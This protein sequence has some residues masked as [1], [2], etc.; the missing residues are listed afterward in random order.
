MKMNNKTNEY[1]HGKRHYQDIVSI[2]DRYKVLGYFKDRKI[3]DIGSSF[4]FF[5]RQ[6]NTFYREKKI[7]FSSSLQNYI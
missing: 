2:K 6:W 4:S 5:K 1:E 3:L 7:Y